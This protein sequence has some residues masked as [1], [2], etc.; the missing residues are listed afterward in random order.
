MIK[1]APVSKHHNII[2][3]DPN[4]NEVRFNIHMKLEQSVFC[5]TL[6]QLYPR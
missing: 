4:R 3:T 1:V 6:R 2:L 5:F